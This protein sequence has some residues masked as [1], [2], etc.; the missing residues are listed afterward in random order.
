MATYPVA[1]K[2]KRGAKRQKDQTKIRALNIPAMFALQRR[3]GI[4]YR[5]L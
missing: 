4:K 2:V 3:E 1:E 5:E